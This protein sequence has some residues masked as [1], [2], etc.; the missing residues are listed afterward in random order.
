MRPLTAGLLTLM[1]AGPVSGQDHVRFKA[2]AETYRLLDGKA[3]AE[4]I[5]L[6]DSL[7]VQS[8]PHGADGRVH[9]IYPQS[10]TRP[11]V[12]CTTTAAGAV[13]WCDYKPLGDIQ[14]YQYHTRIAA[15]PDGNILL[16]YFG[17]EPW[18]VHGRLFDRKGQV[19][20]AAAVSERKSIGHLNVISWSGQGWLISHA[21][22]TH[23]AVQLLNTQGKRLWAGD[24]VTLYSEPV[25]DHNAP[26]LLQ[27]SPGSVFVLWYD[28]SLGPSRRP[29]AFLAQRIDPQGAFLWKAPVRVGDAPLGRGMPRENKVSSTR[30]GGVRADLYKG[31]IS[32]IRIDVTEYVALISSKGEV[33]LTAERKLK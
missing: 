8:L 32:D 7:M 13:A 26:S 11:P 23:V 14:G 21:D 10:G 25:S 19:L 6:A 17:T 18:G 5:G 31:V 12:L 27:D 15:D 9:L 29:P 3:I 20:W 24:G 4:H 2:G 1:A 22:L 28:V 30:D 16:V 33:S